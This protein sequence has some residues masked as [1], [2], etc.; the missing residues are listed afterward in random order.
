M[1]RETGQRGM[2]HLTLGAFILLVLVLGVVLYSGKSSSRAKTASSASSDAD[3]YTS[4]SIS[5]GSETA[6]T[7]YGKMYGDS[8]YE[9]DETKPNII[10]VLADDL[11][12]NSLGYA[13]GIDGES[14]DFAD[15]TPTLTKLAGKGVIM[16]N[17]YAQEVCTP[18]RASLLTGRYPLSMGMQYGVVEP[19]QTNGMSLYETTIAEVLRDAG[20]KTHM[21][22]KWHLGHHSARHLPTARGFDSYVGFLSGESYYWSKKYPKRA[23]FVDF[24]NATTDCYA[25]YGTRLI[26]TH[27]PTQTYTYT[28]LLKHSFLTLSHQHNNLEKNRWCRQTRLLYLH[29]SGL[30]HLHYRGARRVDPSIHLPVFPSCPQSLQ[31]R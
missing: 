18:S 14:Y 17:Y 23:K 9:S 4:S 7:G 11:G 28:T 10:F 2:H 5:V 20:Y 22:G 29:V 21:L 8:V 31:R 19:Q 16:N 15:Y 27:I 3:T 6:S 13:K 12:W 24:M 25:G 26:H 1:M 30:G